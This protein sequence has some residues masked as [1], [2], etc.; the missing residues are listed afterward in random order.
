VT[1]KETPEA[2]WMIFPFDK[3]KR[4]AGVKKSAKKGIRSTGP[5]ETVAPRGKS[6]VDKELHCREIKGQ[7][8]KEKFLIIAKRR[9]AVTF[10]RTTRKCCEIQGGD[11]SNKGEGGHTCSALSELEGTRGSKERNVVE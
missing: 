3:K 11:R 1:K 10:L 7:K 4:K 6:T 2:L 5:S 9:E 8:R